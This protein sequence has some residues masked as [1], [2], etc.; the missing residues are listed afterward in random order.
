MSC[1]RPAAH[2]LL[3][4]WAKGQVMAHARTDS[5]GRFRIA[6]RSRTYTVTAGLGAVLTPARITVATHGFRRVTFRLDSGVR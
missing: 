4:F 2:V 5:K 6:L 1:A 3:K